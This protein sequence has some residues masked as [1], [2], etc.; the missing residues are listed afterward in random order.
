MPETFPLEPEAKA[1][2]LEMARVDGE[3][4]A[5]WQFMPDARA[6]I[7]AASPESDDSRTGRES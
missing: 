2:A 1:M 3:P 7:A 5:W 4:A 6:L